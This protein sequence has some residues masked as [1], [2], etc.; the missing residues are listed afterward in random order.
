MNNLSILFILTNFLEYT[1]EIYNL[2][3]KNI[4]FRINDAGKMYIAKDCHKKK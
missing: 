3:I 1:K 2:L 4:D